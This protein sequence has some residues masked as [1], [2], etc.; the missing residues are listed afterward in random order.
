MWGKCA[1]GPG[2]DGCAIGA[3]GK[4][5]GTHDYRIRRDGL[6]PGRVRVIVNWPAL[7]AG[8]TSP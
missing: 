7:L 6:A 5:E 4:G 2:L 3:A 1:D 8:P